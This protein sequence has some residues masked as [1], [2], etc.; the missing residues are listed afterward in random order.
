[1]ASY[2]NNEKIK[3]VIAKLNIQFRTL[4]VGSADKEL[5]DFI[6]ENNHYSINPAMIETILRI[7]SPQYVTLLSTANLTAIKKANYKPLL[8]Y[9]DQFFESYL[10]NVFLSLEDNIREE[11]GVIIEIL[12]KD[13]LSRELK[14]EII[15]KEQ[16]A[17]LDIT[18]VSDELWAMIFRECKL[19]FDWDNIFRY[20][21]KIKEFDV[22]LLDFLSKEDVYLKLSLKKFKNGNNEEEKA[23]YYNFIK[24]FIYSALPYDAFDNLVKSIPYSYKDYNI[25]GLA[26]QKVDVLINRKILMFKVPIYNR[27]REH[28]H[29]KHINFI[30]NN[31]SKYLEEQEQYPVNNNDLDAILDLTC[32]TNNQKL[33]LISMVEIE[34]ITDELVNKIH[35]VV[36]NA[37]EKIQLSKKLF[38]KIWLSLLKKNRLKFLITQIEFLQTSV[39]TNCLNSLGESFTMITLPRKRPKI[40]YSEDILELAK[41]LKKCDYISSYVELEQEGIKNDKKIQFNTK[42][43]M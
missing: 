24:Q 22:V 6:C 26:P 16:F 7:K 39:L 13:T 32:F 34:S 27:L 31:Y 38:D 14:E 15:Q 2:G 12:N 4:K 28:F 21:E 23:L 36:V 29:G 30:E 10:E 18:E 33:N 19:E 5:F 37:T 1:M 17:L 3:Q 41:E 43:K 40:S 35:L 8:N 11:L 25:D 20:Y 42:I 9:I